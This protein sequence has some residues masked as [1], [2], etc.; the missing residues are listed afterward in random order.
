MSPVEN[1]FK[2][3]YHPGGDQES[4]LQGAVCVLNGEGRCML[5]WNR[6][7]TIGS[8]SMGRI[9]ISLVGLEGFDHFLEI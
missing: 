3:M 2:Y 7:C 4:T 9:T 1:N 6:V 5:I 8:I